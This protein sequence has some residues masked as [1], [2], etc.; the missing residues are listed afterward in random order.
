MPNFIFVTPDGARWEIE[1]PEGTSAMT[2]AVTHGVEGVLAEC[3]GSLACGTCH[4][5]VEPSQSALLPPPA[6]AERELLT[7]TASPARENSRLSCQIV[8]SQGVNGL[9]MYLPERQ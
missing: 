7:T 3:G 9:V 1:V 4:V 5:F 2:A 8:A 6:D